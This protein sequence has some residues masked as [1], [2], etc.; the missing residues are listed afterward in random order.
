MIIERKAS[1]SVGDGRSVTSSSQ[2]SSNILTIREMVPCTPLAADGRGLRTTQLPQPIEQRASARGF[3]LLGESRER[4]G[5][6]ENLRYN[7]LYHASATRTRSSP[8]MRV[9]LQLV[10]LMC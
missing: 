1:R 8:R 7:G 6:M 9:K 5:I 3:P 4:L 2:A 10:I